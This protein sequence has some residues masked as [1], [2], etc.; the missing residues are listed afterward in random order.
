M[1]TNVVCVTACAL[2]V[3]TGSYGTTG[4]EQGVV[5]EL[6]RSDPAR[7]E[8]GACADQA[9]KT[10]WGFVCIHEKGIMPCEVSDEKA[11]INTTLLSE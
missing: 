11:G 9:H 5:E 2:P 6:S 1:A 10:Y 4:S 7:M 3:N 8:S